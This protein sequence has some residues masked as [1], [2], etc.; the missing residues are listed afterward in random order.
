[1]KGADYF[2]QKY[3]ILL[4]GYQYDQAARRKNRIKAGRGSV[5]DSS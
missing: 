2:E 1:M 4:F 3:R 5:C